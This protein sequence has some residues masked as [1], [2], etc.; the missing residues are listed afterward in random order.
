[1]PTRWIDQGAAAAIVLAEVPNRY[2]SGVL[3]V[4]LKTQFSD[5]TNWQHM[6]KNTAFDGPD[7][8]DQKWELEET[9][10]SDLTQYWTEDEKIWEFTYPVLSYPTQVKSLSLDQTPLIKGT[11]TGI[12]GQYLYI[13]ETLVINIR[14]HTGYQ[15]K[16]EN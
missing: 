5:K 7:L 2:L 1:M 9:L 11:L 8:L 6:L 12:R 14:K 10:P 16:W 4:A 15:I 3:E 13:D